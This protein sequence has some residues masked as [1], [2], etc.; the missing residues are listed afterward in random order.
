MMRWITRLNEKLNY[1]QE[2]FML[3]AA[4]T[5]TFTIATLKNSMF[6]YI[7][8]ICLG[9]TTGYFIYHR[10]DDMEHGYKVRDKI[11]GWIR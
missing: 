2:M 5:F 9:I 7:A 1:N 3:F 4:I 10:N 8:S 11:R 6:F